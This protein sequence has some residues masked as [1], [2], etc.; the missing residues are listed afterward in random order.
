MK[1]MTNKAWVALAGCLAVAVGCYASGSGM[2]LWGLILV[3]M[4]SKEFR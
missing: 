4:L 2:P 3:I 1:P